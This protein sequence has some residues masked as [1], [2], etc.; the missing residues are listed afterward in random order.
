M[1]G[2]EKRDAWWDGE[3]RVRSRNFLVELEEERRVGGFGLCA[4]QVITEFWFVRSGSERGGA[5][6]NDWN[7]DDGQ[8][9][10]TSL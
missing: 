7:S 10:R 2:G 3:T 6:I 1:R 4:A 5:M 9:T 8:H